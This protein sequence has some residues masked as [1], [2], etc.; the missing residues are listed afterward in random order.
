MEAAAYQPGTAVVYLAASKEDW[1]PAVVES[2]IDG[3][4]KL[5]VSPSMIPEDKVQQIQKEVQ[6]PQFQAS[7]SGVVGGG[8]D[9]DGRKIKTKKNRKVYGIPQWPEKTRSTYSELVARAAA[10]AE[11]AS[12]NPRLLGLDSADGIDVDVV[13][14]GSGFLS[15]YFLGV[16]T[17]LS[18]IPSLR[19]HRYAGASSGAQVPYQ[20]LLDGEANAVQ[21]YL[22]YGELLDTFTHKL[23]L[24]GAMANADHD[25]HAYGKAMILRNSENLKRLQGR[26]FVSLTKWTVTGP[27]HMQ[28]SDFTDI[29]HAKSAF[30]ATGTALH[31]V[32]G[33]YVSDGGGPGNQ[34]PVFQDGIRH[35]IVVQPVNAG[36]SM[37]QVVRYSFQDAVAAI[38]KGQDDALRFLAEPHAW[39]GPVGDGKPIGMIRART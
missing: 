12:K 18:R 19:L 39:K 15:N 29:K 16:H 17:V 32:D 13:V 24:M 1:V 8:L 3:H 35:Q 34:C 23:G 27:A 9:V 36:I 33:Q 4:Y 10:C 28:V 30:Y 26:M 7:E 14:Q 21:S 20:I 2:Y 31:K 22:A 25:W 5:D 37:S 11:Q 38:Q 6:L